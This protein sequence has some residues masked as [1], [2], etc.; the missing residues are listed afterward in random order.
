MKYSLVWCESESCPFLTV[1]K[2]EFLMLVYALYRPISYPSETA[3]L[4]IFT[5]YFKNGR[6]F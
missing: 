5:L 1:H 2:I 3:Y 6:V 4:H